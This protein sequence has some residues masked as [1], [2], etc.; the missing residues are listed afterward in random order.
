MTLPQELVARMWGQIPAWVSMPPT[1]E[2]VKQN[3]REIEHKR[4]SPKIMFYRSL[5]ESIPI[6]LASIFALNRLLSLKT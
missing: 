3:P 6:D 5:R 4:L 1:G 2:S